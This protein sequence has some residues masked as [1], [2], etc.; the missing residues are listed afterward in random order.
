MIP[1]ALCPSNLRIDRDRPSG[2]SFRWQ[3]STVSVGAS[4]KGPAGRGATARR[5]SKALGA[6]RAAAVW[7]LV[8]EYGES[9]NHAARVV[10]LSSASGRAAYLRAT[11]FPEL[12]RVRIRKA[13]VLP[14][15][16]GQR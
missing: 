6:A 12:E 16:E 4:S 8:E 2:S 1:V 9:V 10:G 7:A 14:W 3:R 15:R 11:R 5:R 13:C